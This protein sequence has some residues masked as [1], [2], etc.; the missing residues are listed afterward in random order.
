MYIVAILTNLSRVDLKKLVKVFTSH[1]KN[2][3]LRG[4]SRLVNNALKKPQNLPK[5]N[6]SARPANATVDFVD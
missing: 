2:G 3:P 6:S 5:I 4:L 1:K